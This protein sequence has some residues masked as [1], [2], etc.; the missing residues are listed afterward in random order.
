M[1]ARPKKW[2]T[3]GDVQRQGLRG[4]GWCA[5]EPQYQLVYAFDT[6]IGNDG[7]TLDTL[8]FDADQW[9]VY[10]THHARAFGN[11]RAFPAY[12]KAQPPK[13]G[14]ELRRRL[15]A[16]DETTLASAL[17]EVL[18]ARGRKALLQRRDALLALPAAE[19]A[20]MTR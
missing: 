19:A 15:T 8:L 14:P 1:Q 18:D 11:A 3:Q 7:R 20:A 4:G 10:A 5:L 16:L 9:Y 17:G 12:L 13:P 2:V 6:L